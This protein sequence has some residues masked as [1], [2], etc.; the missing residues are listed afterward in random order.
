MFTI[1]IYF[2]CTDKVTSKKHNSKRLLMKLTRD[3]LL[4]KDDSCIRLKKKN[5][6]FQCI[7]LSLM[8]V[9]TFFIKQ[10]NNFNCVLKVF[11]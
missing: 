9:F 8:F 11:L 6:T 5:I 7:Y 1:C 4:D 3:T 10:I 2:V